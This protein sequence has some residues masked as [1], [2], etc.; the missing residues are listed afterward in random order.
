MGVEVD[1]VEKL[2][3]LLR[4]GGS[5]AVKGA[6]QQMKKEGEKIA[7]L[8]RLMAP[9]DE[10]DLEKAIQTRAV[11]GGRSE[12][13]Q[14]AQKQIIIEIDGDRPAGVNREGQISVVGDYAYLM[15]EHLTPFGHYRLG[16]RSQAKQAGSSVMVGGK[17]L[18]RAV[19]EVEKGLI[20][21]IIGAVQDG[22]D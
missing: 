18:E 9:V 8:A 14:F 17:Y 4:Q 6:F 13:G 15:H 3:F 5:R 22:L 7:D 19:A 20:N 2:M 1:G 21:R 16:P 10:G 12:G 11:G